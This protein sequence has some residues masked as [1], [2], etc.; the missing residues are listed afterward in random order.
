[1]FSHVGT[2]TFNYESPERASVVGASV[3]REVGEIDDER[4]RTMLELADRRVTITVEARDLVALR[5]AL[6]TWNGLVS[7]AERTTALVQAA[8]NP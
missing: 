4:S 6:N 3:E 1:M 7:V 8:D 2:L 5:A